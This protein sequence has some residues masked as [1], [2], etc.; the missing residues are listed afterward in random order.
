MARRLAPQ[1]TQARLKDG[2]DRRSGRLGPED[3]GAEAR[4]EKAV[5]DR[6]LDLGG[7]QPSLR[8]DQRD[9]GGD[10]APELGQHGSEAPALPL[11][12]AEAEAARGQVGE[13]LGQRPGWLDRR[14]DGPA[15]LLCRLRGDPL[16]ASDPLAPARGLEAHDRALG[17]D[18]GDPRDPEL[19]GG[20]DDRLELVALRHPL[21][22]VIA[23]GDS[24]ALRV[25]DRTVPTAASAVTRS[26]RTV[27][28]RP[29]PSTAAT[30]SP[31]ASRRVRA[32]CRASSAS[33]VSR[34]PSTASGR[35]WKRRRVTAAEGRGSPS[36]RP[37]RGRAGPARRPRARRRRR[38]PR[39]R[40]SPRGSASR[41]GP[42][43]AGTARRQPDARSRAGRRGREGSW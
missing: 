22:S 42:G 37:S 24:A 34:V 31:A 36:R 3:P 7:R 19:G 16:P 20:A 43:A 5:G 25:A 2:H 23:R 28:W 13:E 35:T 11:P 33:N 10:R 12:E 4:R 18:G 8:S 40:G 32:M 26:R 6:E 27:Y 30:R 38:P 17:E 21:A 15:A 14:D 29:L 41:P 39:V 1:V 9:G